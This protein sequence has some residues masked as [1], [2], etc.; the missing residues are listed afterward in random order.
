MLK[1]LDDIL[2]LVGILCVVLSAFGVDWRLG[3]LVLGAGCILCGVLVGR[4]YRN[5]P[6]VLAAIEKAREEKKRGEDA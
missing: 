1:F 4:F 5:H 6:Q 3:F 2:L